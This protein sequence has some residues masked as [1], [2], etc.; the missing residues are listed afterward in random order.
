MFCLVLEIVGKSW[1]LYFFEMFVN[2]F[3]VFILQNFLMCKKINLFRCQF[4]ERIVFDYD[5]E[6]LEVGCYQVLGQLCNFGEKKF[7]YFLS[8]IVFIWK[9]EC[10][11]L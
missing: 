10:Q 7:F 9:M 3:V 5:L 6:S 1:C 4:G 8:F 11:I 2:D